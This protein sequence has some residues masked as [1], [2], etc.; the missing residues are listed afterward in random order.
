MT[1]GEV[2]AYAWAPRHRGIRAFGWDGKLMRDDLVYS[3]F[4]AII[5]I[6]VYG[7]QPVQ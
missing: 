2:G 5:L 4:Y 1:P 3:I 6:Q 7:M